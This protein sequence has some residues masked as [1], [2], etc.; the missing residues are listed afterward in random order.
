MGVSMRV[1]EPS[2]FFLAAYYNMSS[3]SVKNRDTWKR[4][5]FLL[6]LSP[7]A[8]DTEQTKQLRAPDARWID[9][10]TGLSIDVY[11]VRYALNHPEGEGMLSCND[12]SELM[13]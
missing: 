13:V 4:R 3:F 5:S 10:V 8:K 2:L 11:A 1:S 6:E 9:T 12:G 7:H